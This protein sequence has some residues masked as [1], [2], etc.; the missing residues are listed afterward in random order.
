LSA[1]LPDRF[2][3]GEKA[4]VSIEQGAGLASETVWTFLGDKNQLLLQ[5]NGG[6]MFQPVSSSL[7]RLSF[8]GFCRQNNISDCNGGTT[9]KLLL[10][11]NTKFQLKNVTITFDSAATLLNQNIPC[12]MQ[13]L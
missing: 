4:S 10:A 13:L 1:S 2:I 6:P 3:P 11:V 8:C 9:Q 5:G 7:Y 12:K